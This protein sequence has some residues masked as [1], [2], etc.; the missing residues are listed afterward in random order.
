MGNVHDTLGYSQRREKFK[1][2]SRR[3]KFRRAIQQIRLNY[4]EDNFTSNRDT[5][6]S[7]ALIII[8][9][10]SYSNLFLST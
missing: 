9:G 2:P 7:F 1:N 10:L 3:K 8:T 5:Q 4:I 6:Y